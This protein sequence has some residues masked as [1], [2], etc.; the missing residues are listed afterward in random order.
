MVRKPLDV[1]N[2]TSGLL[3]YAASLRLQEQLVQLR[4]AGLI[5]D[6]LLLVQVSV[7]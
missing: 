4:K 5:N 1:W 2:L 6:T 3:K 7:A